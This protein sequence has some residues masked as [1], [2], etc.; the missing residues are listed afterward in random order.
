M[1]VFLNGFAS[2]YI[3]PDLKKVSGNRGLMGLDFWSI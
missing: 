2:E 1:A 3:M